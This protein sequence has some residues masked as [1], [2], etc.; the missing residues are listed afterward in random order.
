MN[1]PT[2]LNLGMLSALVIGGMIGSGIFN[3]PQNMAASAGAAAILVGWLITGFGML[4]LCCVY[5]TLSVSKPALNNGVYAY[6]RASAGE[7]VGFNSAWGYWVSAWLS[8]V[9]YLI[10]IF[11]ALGYFFPIFGEGNTPA[12]IFGASIILWIMHSFI[13]RGIKNAALLNTVITIAKMLPLLLFISLTFLAFKRSIFQA[14]LWGN[15]A[16]TSFL[17]QVKNIML[18]TVW[19]FIGIE[20]ASVYSAR[21]KLRS[22]IGKATFIGFLITLLLLMAVS[23][24]SLGI[25]PEAVLANLKNLSMASILESVTGRGA[26]IMILGFLLSTGGALLTWTLLAAEALFTP[27]ND[28]LMPTWFGKKNNREV[29]ANTLW[30]TNMLIQLFL[31]ITLLSKA[32]YLALIKLDTSMILIPYLF[33]AFYAFKLALVENHKFN[34]LIGLLALVYCIWLLYAAGLKYLLLSALLYIPGCIFYIIAKH[35]QESPLFKPFEWVI[36]CLM[37]LLAIMACYL[38]YVGKLTL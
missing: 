3:L 21:A 17:Q 30:L 23:L 7:F 26:I 37:I 27:A 31:I 5:Q 33:S 22:D 16:T 4:M 6:A 18:V 34:S 29:P 1:T 13:L 14:N 19:V 9:S 15:F 24:L 2:K 38:L 20:G 25:L 36:L 11:G 35:Q 10:A 32:T 12:A 28:G 8:N